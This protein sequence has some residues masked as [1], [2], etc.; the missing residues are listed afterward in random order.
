ML[1]LQRSKS[2]TQTPSSTFALTLALSLTLVAC[3]SKPL[4]TGPPPPGTATPSAS[5]PSPAPGK[6]S[7]P[8]P[9]T[10]KY[11]DQDGPPLELPDDLANRPDALPRSD[12]LSVAANRPYNVFGQPYVPMT[13]I[14]DFR[15]RGIGSWYG[16]MFHGRKTSSGEVY[17]MFAMTAAHPTLPIPSYAR[18]TNTQTGKQVIVRVNDRG[19][20]LHSRVIDLSYA[21]AYR[22]GYAQA[23]SGEVEVELLL[24]QQIAQINA[25]APP[26]VPVPA[27]SPAPVNAPIAAQPVTQPVVTLPSAPA[28]VLLANAPMPALTVQPV[29]G[30]AKPE[31]RPA[32]PMPAAAAPAAPAASAAKAGPQFYIQLGAFA[33]RE[34]A[35]AAQTRV[36]AD[37]AAAVKAS[38]IVE[39]DRLFKLQAGPY[40]NRR[41]LE[42][43]IAKIK[44]LTN[45]SVF[46]VSR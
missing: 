42:I 22:L 14:T 35:Q 39:Q 43:A 30:P 41:D 1:M 40:A 28:P 31:A 38:E 18:V 44:Q 9:S 4:R 33:S 7:A 3:S 36:A 15:Q 29:P 11:Y 2:Q 12:P 17:D 16:R 20:F 23:G 24:P 45:S 21:A 37:L 6:P 34:N 46:S 25:N 8:V 5:S 32:T 19:P 10:G 13:A 27:I 26:Q